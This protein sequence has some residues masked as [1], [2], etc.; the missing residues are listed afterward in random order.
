MK[1]L[2]S[3]LHGDAVYDGLR[4]E[5]LKMSGLEIGYDLS[6]ELNNPRLHFSEEDIMDHSC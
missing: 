6:P 1:T 2:R 3:D 5:T 4:V